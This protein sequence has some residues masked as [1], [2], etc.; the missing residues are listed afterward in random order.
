MTKSLDLSPV[1]SLAE[2]LVIFRQRFRECDHQGRQ[3][4]AFL[5]TGRRMLQA[6]G[7]LDA[8]RIS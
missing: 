8:R 3:P 1:R 2:E 5:N 7:D 6:S 4:T